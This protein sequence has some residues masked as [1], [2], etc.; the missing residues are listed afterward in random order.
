MVSSEKFHDVSDTS[1]FYV[2]PFDMKWNSEI[3]HE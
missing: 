2:I 1:N 3:K